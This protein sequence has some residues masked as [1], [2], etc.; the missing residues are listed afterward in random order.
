MFEFNS[1]EHK[2]YAWGCQEG[3]QEERERIVALLK[4]S[5]LDVELFSAP[6]TQQIVELIDSETE[7]T[8][9]YR[10]GTQD[11]RDRII[12]LLRKL[13]CNKMHNCGKW[14]NH[15]SYKLYELVKLINGET[16]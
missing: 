13:R 12:M 10:Q 15:Y 8:R 2:A 6:Y 3:A 4:S 7:T 16:S 5:N 1:P 9:A 14:N 11:E